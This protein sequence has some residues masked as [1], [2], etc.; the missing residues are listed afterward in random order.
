VS[1]IATLRQLRSAWREDGVELEFHLTGQLL[2]MQHELFT[3]TIFLVNFLLLMLEN[4][5]T[6]LPEIMRDNYT[7]RGQSASV[8]ASLL[9]YIAIAITTM[10]LVSLHATFETPD[11]QHDFDAA[12]FYAAASASSFSWSTPID[13]AAVPV[14]ILPT[15]YSSLENRTPPPGAY[16]VAVP[17]DY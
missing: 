1:L 10:V 15:S 17:L 16:A 11:H 3:S 6:S 9:A 12:S 14:P 7:S 13:A 8:V 5:G 2:A 4:I